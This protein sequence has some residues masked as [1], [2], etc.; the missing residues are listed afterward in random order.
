VTEG[1]TVVIPAGAEHEAFVDGGRSVEFVSSMLTGTVMI[2]PNGERVA[3]P[4][5]E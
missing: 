4:W 5:T 3:P 1:D 2:R